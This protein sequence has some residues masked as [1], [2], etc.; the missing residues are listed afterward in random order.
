MRDSQ[1]R[2]EI[3]ETRPCLVIMEVAGHL[4]DTFYIAFL[5]HCNLRE[6]LYYKLNH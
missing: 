6:E 4:M 1:H 2:V 3:S 5:K